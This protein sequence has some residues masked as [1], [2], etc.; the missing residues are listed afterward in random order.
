MLG[1]SRGHGARAG[2]H[3]VYRVRGVST[4]G[5]QNMEYAGTVIA[6]GDS[7]PSALGPD[8]SDSLA[9]RQTAV[10]GG[11]RSFAPIR[12]SRQKMTRGAHSS[13]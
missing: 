5:Q 2:T 7:R 9:T 1:F 3:A 8:L 10:R 4:P 13:E 12:P 6:Y 11:G